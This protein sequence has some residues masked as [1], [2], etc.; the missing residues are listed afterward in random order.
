M[1]LEESWGLS[2]LRLFNNTLWQTSPH[3]QRHQLLPWFRL[4]LT[5]KGGR[6]AAVG[7]AQRWGRLL[8]AGQSCRVVVTQGTRGKRELEGVRHKELGSREGQKVAKVLLC[9]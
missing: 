2:V 7:L 9:L 3:V 6:G 4:S 5:L 1:R 8:P